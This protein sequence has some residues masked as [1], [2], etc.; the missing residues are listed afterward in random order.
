MR[1][2]PHSLWLTVL[3]AAGCA[4]NLSESRPAR[5]LRGGEM[6]ISNINSVVVP[7][8]SMGTT[9]DAGKT[10]AQKIDQR[11]SD[12]D[13]R[14][15]A[16]SAAAIGLTGPGYAN[17]LEFALGLGYRLDTALRIGNGI[18]SA[19]IRRGFDL[20]KWDSNIGV[21]VGYNSGASVISY[22]DT[23]NSYAKIGSTKRIDTSFTAQIGREFGEW[24]K[25]WAAAKAMYSRY[26]VDVDAENLDLG[27]EKLDD[28]LLY[29][30]GALGLALGFRWVHFVMEL[31]I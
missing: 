11:T 9:I 21:R 22:L 18:Y 23:I 1:R 26:W 2:Q 8:G 27:H 25:L 10:I 19:A 20:G 16:G 7:M 17:H 5:V 6:Q 4:V 13:K 12:A 31:G 3:L 29:Y 15:L 28:H 14:R 24:A 30:G